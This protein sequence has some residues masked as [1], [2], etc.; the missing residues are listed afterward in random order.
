MK[1]SI[2]ST[3]EWLSWR[4]ENVGASEVAAVFGLHQ[5]KSHLKLWAEKSLLDLPPQEETGPMLRGKIFE[6]SVAAVVAL[7]R[8]D[9]ILTKCTE[10]FF[11]PAIR[12]G[13]SPDYWIDGDPRGR[14]VL[15]CKTCSP[16][17]FDEQFAGEAPP[18]WIVMQTAT[19]R[20]LTG[21]AF[22]YCAVLT[23]DTWRAPRWRIFPVPENEKAERSIVAGVTEFWRKVDAGE[24]PA[25]DPKVDG[26]LLTMLHSRE[27]PGMVRDLTGDNALP[28]LLEERALAMATRKEIDARLEEISAIVKDK[29]GD[30]EHAIAQG[31]RM[32]WKV[33]PRKGYTVDPSEPRVLRIYKQKGNDA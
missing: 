7:E 2:T 3:N 4:R 26:A 9:W 24:Q 12:L 30:C 33:E 13:A 23:V 25:A 8:P 1:R 6:P 14:G 17:A 27:A 22:A 31:W 20:M 11:E 32:R 28:G 16:Q 29:I 19:E 5:Y 18:F 21:A 15:Q 10:Y